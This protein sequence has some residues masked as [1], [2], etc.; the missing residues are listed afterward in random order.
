MR[1]A[2]VIF[3]LATTGPVGLPVGDPPTGST[4]TASVTPAASWRR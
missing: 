4:D 1:Q 2:S 3:P